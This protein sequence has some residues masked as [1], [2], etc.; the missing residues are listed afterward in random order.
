[1]YNSDD[2]SDDAN[3]TECL[4]MAFRYQ[5]EE[6]Q[7]YKNTIEKIEHLL[8]LRNDPLVKDEILL[9]IK[10]TKKTQAYMEKVARHV[11]AEAELLIVEHDKKIKRRLTGS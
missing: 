8:L 7:V 11:V 2:D 9:L 4:L 3:E 6:I 5:R 1:M 10:E